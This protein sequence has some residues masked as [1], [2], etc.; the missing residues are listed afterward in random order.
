MDQTMQARMLRFERIRF[1]YRS[2]DQWRLMTRLPGLAMDLRSLPSSTSLLSDTNRG[3]AIDRCRD[4]V[5]DRLSD[6]MTEQF[7]FFKAEEGW[8]AW[9]DMMIDQTLP[10]A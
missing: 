8:T 6:I 4:E 5:I 10:R 1:H 2:S 9:Y 3:P 7:N